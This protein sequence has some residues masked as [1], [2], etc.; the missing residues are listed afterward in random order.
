MGYLELY[1]FERIEN[2]KRKKKKKLELQGFD[3]RASPTP[4]GCSTK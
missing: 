1:L 2:E 4:R 3:P